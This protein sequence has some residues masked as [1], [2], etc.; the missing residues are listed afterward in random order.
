MN[1]D[2]YTGRLCHNYYLYQDSFGVFNPIIWDMNLS[3]G[4]FRY[5]GTGS[6]LSNEKMQ[7]LSPFVHYKS[8]NR[9]LISQVLGTSLF[10]KVYIAHI[11]TILKDFFTNNKY[12]T[13]GA[14]LHRLIDRFVQE[15]GNKLY[16]YDSFKK[17]I[18][19]TS[20]AGKSKI[21][22][23]NEL[24]VGRSQ[25][26]NA[27]PLLSKESP[28]ITNVRHEKE[29]EK[30]YISAK[31]PKSST[32]WLMYRTTKNGPFKRVEMSDNGES[33][34]QLIDD[35]IY[36]FGL[37]YSAGTQYYI[38]AEMEKTA[39]LSPERASFEFHKIP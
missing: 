1:L 30:V 26:L 5:D 22:G 25:Y 31:V 36:G 14:E 23:L 28:M 12:Q 33:G 8:P 27:H 38:I 29:G 3:F 35:E 18:R 10:R 17:N 21:I 11:K 32:V 2:S 16:S 13:R 37:N 4:G 19:E 7:K 39:A 15:D 34:D 9:P 20:M 6:P 24:M